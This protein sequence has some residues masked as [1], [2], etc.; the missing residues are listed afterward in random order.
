[1]T[2]YH[3][4]TE[5]VTVSHVDRSSSDSLSLV[6]AQKQGAGFSSANVLHDFVHL[7]VQDSYTPRSIMNFIDLCAA[8]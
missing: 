7:L 6:R 4:W 3:M 1:M 8:P 2:G 5:A